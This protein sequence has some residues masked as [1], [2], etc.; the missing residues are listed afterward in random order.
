MGTCDGHSGNGAVK[1]TQRSTAETPSRFGSKR[2]GQVYAN[3]SGMVRSLV[4]RG[5]HRLLEQNL[6]KT[7]HHRQDLRLIH[8]I[9]RESAMH[10]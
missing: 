6:T 2:S 4:W 8:G 9:S 1:H 7:N 5:V 3:R 10:R